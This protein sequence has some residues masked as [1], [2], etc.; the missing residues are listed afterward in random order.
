VRK[1]NAARSS[2]AEPRRLT[3]SVEIVRVRGP[4][5]VHLAEVQMEAIREVLTW[6]LSQHSTD[7]HLYGEDRAA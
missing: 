5:A 3:S 7:R 2:G 1:H 4:D 6:A